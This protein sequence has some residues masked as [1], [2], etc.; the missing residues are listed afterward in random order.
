MED[1]QNEGLL[2]VYTRKPDEGCYTPSL[3]NSIHFAFSEDGKSYKPMNQNFGIVYAPASISLSNTI[4]EKGLK[5]PFLFRGK[6]GTYCIAAVRTAAGGEIDAESKGSILLW[7][8]ADLINFKERGLV[9][10]KKNAYVQA[11]N[12]V[13]READNMYEI[14]WRDAGGNYFVNYLEE[15]EDSFTASE[16]AVSSPF[17]QHT[18]QAALPDI[19]PGNAIKVD[20]R[21]GSGLLKHWSPLFNVAV[22]VPEK[23]SAASEED[24]R[25]VGAEIVYSDGSMA[26]KK[27]VWDTTGLDFNRAGTYR[28]RGKVV[29]EQYAF[30]LAVGY[31]D[32]QVFKWKGKYYF[33]ATNDN[34][35]AIGLFVREA[36]TIQGLFS[37]GIL[38]QVI[39]DFD[40]ERQLVKTFWAPEFHEIG[41]EL[42]I[43]FAV[44]GDTGGPQSH[45]M[46][47]KNGGSIVNPKDWEDPVRVC[48]RD[49][50]YLAR[51]GITLDM[52]Y[53][54][55]DGA[56]Y[57]VWS[58]RTGF[59]TP[60]DTGSMLYIAATD[61]QKPWM[62]TSEPV[63]LSRPLLG[64]E[65]NHGTVNNEGPYA[66]QFKDKVYL[67][68][69]GGA[70]GGCS[71]AIGFLSINLNGNP[72]N[73]TEWTKT[74]TPALSYCSVPGEYGPGHNTF[75]TDEDGSVLVA[76]HAQETPGNTPRCTAVR[77]VHFDING[78]PVLN[79]CDERALNE[80]FANVSM[81]VVLEN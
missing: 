2:L 42:Y 8:S 38:E 30:P 7:T 50:S 9:D 22:R 60:D 73:P 24:I 36:D 43:L 71:Y 21:F 3:A 5:S 78:T 4:N 29:Q 55:V 79:L 70:A 69:S 40:K 27:V 68:F 18:L 65:N 19:V 63:L 44:R 64:W 26:R 62:L 15:A 49:G 57:L 45:M 37:E 53:M 31:A 80:E 72:L 6:D 32:P 25:A 16:A 41:G 66:L 12:C 23:V 35:G 47:L 34:T 39:L 58:F 74:C 48:R 20:V 13:Y 75:F 14:R 46:R 51:D 17:E 33:I 28:I 59:G 1:M 76:Y 11:L 54:N 56:A 67:A 77:R 61:T 81:S 52:T 10:L